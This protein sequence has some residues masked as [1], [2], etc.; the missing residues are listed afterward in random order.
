MT[1]FCT[2]CGVQCCGKLKIEARKGCYYP[3]CSDCFE[4]FRILKLPEIRKILKMN[5]NYVTSK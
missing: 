4:S 3:F 5:K 2:N 1:E